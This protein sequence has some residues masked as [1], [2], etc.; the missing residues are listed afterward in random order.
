MAVAAYTYDALPADV[1]QGLPDAEHLTAANPAT[2]TQRTWS[3]YA[4]R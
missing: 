3:Q 1:R 4:H 2:A